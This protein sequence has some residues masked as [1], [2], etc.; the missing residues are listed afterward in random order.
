MLKKRFFKVSFENPS[1][2]YLGNGIHAGTNSLNKKYNKKAVFNVLH[3]FFKSSIKENSREFF[4]ILLNFFKLKSS[5]KLEISSI[6][7]NS[8]EFSLILLNYKKRFFLE[9]FKNFRNFTWGN[10]IHAG[11]DF[12]QKK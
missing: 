10:G 7:K 5:T 11:A 1:K 6:K 9:S 2:L 8:R 3:I 4:L 12:L